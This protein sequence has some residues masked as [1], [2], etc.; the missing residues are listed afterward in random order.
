M[1]GFGSH[2]DAS[3][4]ADYGGGSD[5]GGP[6]GA[7]DSRG[8]GGASE[9]RAGLNEGQQNNTAVADAAT[10]SSRGRQDGP[11][12]ANFG[13]G[14]SYNQN[15]SSIDVGLSV[16]M[17]G[18]QLGP[19]IAGKKGITTEAASNLAGRM[20]VGQL[21][22]SG[23]NFGIIGNV[24]NEI[25]KYVAGQ[26]FDQ[27]VAGAN[28]VYGARGFI[29]GAETDERGLVAGYRSGDISNEGGNKASDDG[30]FTSSSDN[31][32]P[33]DTSVTS[34]SSAIAI[35]DYEKRRSGT[36]DSSGSGRRSLL[37]KV[38]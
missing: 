17:F 8:G 6:A 9:D 4:Q 37:R 11:N 10:S 26:V 13:T 20:N 7:A 14:Q 22:M 24:F 12:S 36:A 23:L 29:T 16:A 38:Y 35:S 15:H 1:Y 28:P 3:S 32:Q 25:G 21:E 30:T 33:K 19:Q 5:R 27:I 18:N 34:A 31:D 2:D